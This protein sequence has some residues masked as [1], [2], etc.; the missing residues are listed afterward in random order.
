MK[1]NEAHPNLRGQ[2][3]RVHDEANFGCSCRAHAQEPC[4]VPCAETFGEVSL[5][6]DFARR[7]SF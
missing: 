6:E 1:S 2:A 5:V 3:E 7:G 4:Y